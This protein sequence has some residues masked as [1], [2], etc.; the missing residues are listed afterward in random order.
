VY[1]LNLIL[2]SKVALGVVAG[3]RA[4]NRKKQAGLCPDNV[5][6]WR[7]WHSRETKL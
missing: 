7:G 4:K 2:I 3:R 5:A 1:K 6:G